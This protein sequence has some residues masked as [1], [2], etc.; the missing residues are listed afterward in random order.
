MFF[1]IISISIEKNKIFVC[2]LIFS[3]YHISL[4]KSIL[5]GKWE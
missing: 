4:L 1:N 3:I 2:V 5:W